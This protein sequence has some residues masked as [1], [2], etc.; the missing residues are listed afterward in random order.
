MFLENTKDYIHFSRLEWKNIIIWSWSNILLLSDSYD[1][2]G[3]IKNTDE[4]KILEE[5]DEKVIIEVHSWYL[6]DM[7]VQWTLEHGYT[8]LE[9]MWLIPWTIGWWALGNI[10]AYGKEI[11]EF[12]YAVSY[13]D[14]HDLNIKQLT[15][16]QC[17]YSYRW[18]IFKSLSDY[19]ISSVQF[20]IYKDKHE[21]NAHYPDIQKYLVDHSLK[22]EDLTAK[23]LY[24]IVCEIRTHKMPSRNE[25]GTAGSFRKNPIVSTDDIE[26]IQTIDPDLKFFPYENNFKLAAGRLLE[27]LGY[28]W[29]IIRMPSWGSIGC[30][31]NQALLVVNNGCSWAE[32]NEFAR[33]CEQ[34]VLERYGVQLEREVK[35]M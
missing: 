35:Y 18:S 24:Q 14:L 23:H 12:I 1:H 33:S 6:R 16:D 34:A 22:T 3:I 17:Q 11:A 21:L 31:R 32:V 2:V 27:N 9:N 13:L 28:K 7:F 5:D 8:G 25:R 20:I 26:R 15:N 19:I 4:P 10:G 30:Y 29:K